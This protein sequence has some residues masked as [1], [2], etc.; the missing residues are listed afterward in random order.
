ML[1]IAVLGLGRFGST[2]AVELS[3]GGAEVLAVDRNPRFMEA[4]A[5]KVSVAV[6]FD[7][8][9]LANLQAYD[10]QNMDVAIVAIGSNFEASVLITM[11]CKQLGVDQVYAKALNDM[12]EAVLLK[13]GADHVV[14]PEEDMAGKL[15]EHILHHS[16]VDFVEL[17]EGFS[18]RRIPAPSDWTGKTLEE[19]DLRTRHKINLI[20]VLRPIPG[21][22]DGAVE[23]TP[24]PT[25]DFVLASGDMV[26][27]V[28]PDKVLARWA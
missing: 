6:G 5:D 13:V 17:P 10:V 7:A 27:V 3:R 26:D 24:L 4:V 18:L 8:T 15:S 28:G 22:A 1:K 14:K 20:Q 21:D 23:K 12:Q 19:L 2:L 25:R 11:H 16:V 9:D